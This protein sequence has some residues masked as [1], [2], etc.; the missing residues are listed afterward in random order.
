MS[1]GDCQDFDVVV[2]GSGSAGGTI[3]RACAQAGKHVA[4]IDSRPFGGTC[5]LRGCD[6]K[7]VLIGAAEIV[8]AYERLADEGVFS[9]SP[10]IAWSKLMAFKRRF[11]EPVSSD[12]ENEFRK[13]GITRFHGR[14]H[15]LD[16][17]TLEVDSARL[18]ARHIAIAAGAMHRKLGIPGENFLATSTD[19]LDLVELPRR[20]V[21]VGGGYI[22]F[23]LAHLA[24]RAGA[25]VEILHLNS[26]P[27]GTFDAD[28]VERLV[29]L[30]RDEG[31]VV[32]LNFSVESIGRDAQGVRLLS[33]G[34]EEIVADLAVHGA[35]RV[36]EI[37]DLRLEAAG[38]SRTQKGVAV[39]AYLQS[40]TNP[41]VY[42]AGDAADA[43]GAPLTPVAGTEGE[44]VATNILDGN[45]RRAEFREVATVVYTIPPLGSVGLTEAEA[46]SKGID[47]DINEGD[48]TKWFSSARL[49]ARGSGYKVVSEKGSG[50]VLGASILGPN[51][52]EL[53]NIFA[54]AIRARLSGADLRSILFA[55]PTGAS[56]IEYML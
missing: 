29:V 4:V 44:I 12:R 25:K 9:G 40:E 5:A 8:D 22:S 43:G 24:A 11:T 33:K 18:S 39:N 13:L 45:T 34:G 7:R 27:L 52:E 19:F 20:I 31:I 23:E 21:F 15:F 17:S 46:R 49:A 10:V 56:D 35:G 47:V 55:Y 36:P 28:L 16:G 50:R 41:A 53:T 3:A 30:T 14:A 6:P 54:I 51:A 37:D 2:I 38:V 32:R 26:S 48:S 42:A 1:E